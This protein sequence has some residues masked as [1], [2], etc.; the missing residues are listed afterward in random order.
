VIAADYSP[1]APRIVA[2]T[3]ADG[4]VRPIADGVTAAVTPDGTTVVYATGGTP[5]ELAAIPIGGG[6]ARGLGTID[7]RVRKLRVGPDGVV[8]AMVDRDAVLEAWRVSLTGGAAVRELDPPWCFAQPAPAGGAAVW[9]RCPPGAPVEGV[10]VRAGTIPAAD[11]PGFRLAGPMFYGGDFDAT[12]T[13]YFAYDQPA[14]RRIDVATGAATT[15][16][17][18]AMFGETVSPDGA[19]IYTTEAVGAARRHL[20]TNFAT[21]PRQ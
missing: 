10:I 17:E 11:A 13:V 6:A 9:M 7:G 21:R 5:A 16:V 18:A 14:V 1:L 3:I 4:G 20:I 8:H 19:T 12:G 15:L 2:V